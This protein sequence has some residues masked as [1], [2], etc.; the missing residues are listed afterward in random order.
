[1]QQQAAMGEQPRRGRSPWF[2]VALAGGGCGV[3][4]LLLCAALFL[5]G[6][7]LGR[8]I[9]GGVTTSWP[10]AAAKTSMQL[11]E[12][13]YLPDDAEEPQILPIGMGE[14]FQTVTATYPNGLVII[15]V[16][17]DAGGAGGEPVEVRGAED[18]R[19]TATNGRRTLALRKG[20]TSV[21]LAGLADAELIRVA[22]LLRPVEG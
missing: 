6:S 11:Y 9:S 2:W 19:F 12:P 8:Q 14:T 21:S 13:G 7:F 15:Q 10:D 3:L 17:Q 20:G 5:G 16:N 4:L 22:E 1:M 18:A